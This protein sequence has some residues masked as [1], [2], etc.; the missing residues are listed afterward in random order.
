[1][2]TGVTSGVTAPL[3]I[4]GVVIVRPC[5]IRSSKWYV[6]RTSMSLPVV[7]P[8]LA[9]ILHSLVLAVDAAVTGRLGTALIAAISLVATVACVSAV[10]TPIEMRCPAMYTITSP[11]CCSTALEPAALVITSVLLAAT[12]LPPW[13]MAITSSVSPRSALALAARHI[14]I[15]IEPS[16]SRCRASDSEVTVTIVFSARLPVPERCPISS[17]RRGM[18]RKPRTA[19]EKSNFAATNGTRKLRLSRFGM[20]I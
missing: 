17:T 10:V 2:I 18:P 13:A 9:V 20:G 8:Q 7:P 16:P 6:L 3:A 12:A 15:S 19:R 4:A 5:G 14:C 1:M 11:A